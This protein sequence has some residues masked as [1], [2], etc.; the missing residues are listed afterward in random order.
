MIGSENASKGKSHA[1]LEMVAPFSDKA[2]TD[3]CHP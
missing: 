1:E 2:N 3:C